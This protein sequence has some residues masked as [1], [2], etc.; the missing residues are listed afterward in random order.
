M[1]NL[2]LNLLLLLGS[3]A[4]L[5]QTGMNTPWMQEL[6]A[7]GDKS[8]AIDFSTIQQ[9]FENYWKGKDTTLKGIGYKQF[10]RWEEHWKYNLHE[11]GTLI[12]PAEF[13][14]L[15]QEKNAIS[16]RMNDESDWTSSGP[17]DHVNSGSWSSGQGRLNAVAV[18]PQ[19]ADVIYVGAP[20]GGIWKSLDAGQTWEPLSDYLP[21]IG[22]SAI[23]IH[24]TNTNIIY[25][26]TGD[27]DAGDTYSVGVL[28]TIDGGITW[29][30][31]DLSFNGTG[32]RINEIYLDPSDSDKIF[33]SSNNGFYRSTDAGV[34]FTRT[35]FQDLD[36]M[37]LMPGNSDVI[38]AAT[39]N[40]VYRSTDNGVSFS[41]Q[42]T[43]LPVSGG[44]TV[45]ATSAAAPNNVYVLKATNG[46]NFQGVYQ[47]NDGG[48]SYARIDNGTDIFGGSSQA[49]YD[50]AFDVS[51]TNPNEMFMGV[52]N[53]WKSANGG[54][55]FSQWNSWNAPNSARY[56]HADIHQIR[57]IG[58]TL[59]FC[60]D[61]GL[62]TSMDGNTTTDRTEGLVISQFYRIS[63]AEQT[64]QKMVGGLQDNGGYGYT[65]DI[66]HNYYGADGMDN[67]INPNNE[68]E[69]WGFTQFGGGLY[70][71]NNGGQSIAGSISGAGGGNWITPIAI[72]GDE[73]IFAGYGRLY[74]LN[75]N[76]FTQ[77]SNNTGTIDV[78]ELDPLDTDIMYVG[79]NNLLK[80]S[81]D[82]GQLFT[83]V[84][85]FP[86]NITSIEVNNNNNNLIYVTTSG[87]NGRVYKS[88]DGGSSFQNI[89]EN[90]PN[91]PK[92]VIKH[93]AQHPDNPLFLGTS[94]SV[95]RYDDVSGDWSVFAN[96]LP[97]VPIRDLEINLAD[98]NL[99]AATYGRGVWQSDI[100]IV[101]P[102]YDIRL[103]S[104]EVNNE[105]SCGSSL[106][107][108]RV[109]NKG[110][111]DITQI[112]FD[113][114]LDGNSDQFIWNGNLSSLEETT[115]D[116]PITISSS[117]LHSIAVI[118]TIANDTY[119]A[120]NEGATT[121]SINSSGVQNDIY[122]FEGDGDDLLVVQSN[123]PDLWE[124]GVPTGN[125][126]NNAASGTRV[127]GT[128]LDGQHGNNVTSY[129]LSPCYNLSLMDQPVLKFEMAFQLELN[130][131]V[132]Y[133]EYSIDGGNTWDILG[134]ANDA[135]W[136]NSNY[137]QCTLCT[138]AQWTGET[139]TTMASYSYDLTAFSNEEE[140]IARFVFKS[141]QAV[142]R[143]GVVI[144][145]FVIE[146]QQLSNPSVELDGMISIYPN[147]SKEIINIS[148]PAYLKDL[149]IEMIDVTGKLIKSWRNNDVQEKE[150]ALDI[151][152]FATGVYFVRINSNLGSV[153]KRI[154]KH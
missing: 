148:Y 21:Q 29:N 91:T 24:P 56:T 146:S 4:I 96:N 140:F 57:Y 42:S 74:Q 108:V 30:M 34:N 71:S 1:K 151:S 90:L 141:D 117:G 144:D 7:E 111:N 82:H 25:I 45:L 153:S 40:R 44:R 76:S 129:L 58:N 3:I 55:S 83:N 47:S 105:I 19:N 81:T 72:N 75:G 13:W 102:A 48:S 32:K 52:V 130:W 54:Q 109:E 35:L 104:V 134:T 59:F 138:G 143:E 5:A 124:R 8:S 49:W 41:N 147:P 118:A 119:P 154:I 31:T 6:S 43:G 99:T 113:Y 100:P 122:D 63:V 135:N 78:L 33:V 84:S 97:N 38:Y 89:S 137:S 11:N 94:L 53:V 2:I 16:N 127:Y 114:I 67:I 150:A 60:T 107:K 120:N 85:S 12:T 145:D 103:L 64:S 115:V 9:S 128:N 139:S 61:G 26:G 23:A 106:P 86:T 125:V 126:L 68:N 132:A 80:K 28:K 27:D 123:G 92:L 133:V 93:Q 101:L 37:K 152:Q 51:D 77:I 36:D 70:Y 17:Y 22:V 50:L 142:T 131:D 18:D 121:F 136:Y 15:W 14:R 10:K 69:I 62:Y 110:V 66:W 39:A 87:S 88:V 98:G 95:Y 65:N 46:F 79:V 73:E 149:T 20:A 116:F 112:V